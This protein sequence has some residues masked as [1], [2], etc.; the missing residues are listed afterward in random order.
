MI[1]IKHI[2]IPGT[3]LSALQVASDLYNARNNPMW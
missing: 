2:F 1:F 3:I